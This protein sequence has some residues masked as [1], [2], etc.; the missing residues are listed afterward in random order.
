M[1]DTVIKVENLSKLYTIR[2][3]NGRGDGLRHAMHNLATTPLRWLR[4]QTSAF[5]SQQ[6][7]NNNGNGI[8]VPDVRSLTSDLRHPSS[9]EFWALKDVSFEVKRGEV[10]GIIGRNG[11]GKT[12]LLKILQPHHRA[13]R[14]TRRRCAAASPACSKSAPAFTPS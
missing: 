4:N 11:A 5:R 10:V 8:A 6:S 7:V 2:H 3:R 9:E 1:S 14:G 13:D 12:T